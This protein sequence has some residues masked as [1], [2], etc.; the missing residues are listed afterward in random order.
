MSRVTS[1]LQLIQK[2]ELRFALADTTQKFQD[3]LNVYLAPLLLKFASQD[4]QVKLQLGKMIKFL[5]SK[6]N[7]TPELKFPAITLYEQVKSPNL[8]PNQDHTIVQS[9]TLLF[10]SKAIPRLEIDEKFDM[11][12]KILTG[13]SDMKDSVAARLFNIS[14]RLLVEL[15]F[16]KDSI[17]RIS[18]ILINLNESDKAYVTEKYYKF[19]ML[20]PVQ[21]QSNGII[22]NNISQHGL[23]KADCS[24]FLYYAGVTFNSSSLLEYKQKILKT[25][26]NVDAD[27]FDKVL[28]FLCATADNNSAIASLASTSMKRISLEYENE[29]FIETLV[30]LFTGND[31]RQ[32]VKSTLQEKILSIL[33]KSKIATHNNT[34]EKISTIGLNSTN[35]RLKQATVAFVKWFTT[36]NSLT[37]TNEES[38]LKI[39][40]QL[41]LNLSDITEDKS[42]PNH[43]ENRR[44][45]YE[46]LGL[47]LKKSNG[48]LDVPYIKFLF[49]MLSADD[50]SLQPTIIEALLGLTNSLASMKD[51]Q[52]SSLKKLL[53]NILETPFDGSTVNSTISQRRFIAVKFNN[54]SFPFS[55]AQARIMNILAQ[56]PFDKTETIEEAKKGL[57]PYLFNLN[58]L[59]NDT[60]FPS[61]HTLVKYFLKY[62][63]SIN[64][65]AAVTFALRCLIMNSIGSND[66]IVALDEHWETRVDK[67]LELDLNVKKAVISKINTL[68]DLEGDSIDNFSNSSLKHFLEFAFHCIFKTNNLS[69]LIRLT[70]II[71]LSPQFVTD[72]MSHHV[73]SL[74]NNELQYA[75]AESARYASQ[76]LGI[77]ATTPSISNGRL[78]EIIDQIYQKEHIAALGYVI[79]RSV[80]RGRYEVVRSIDFDE[81][82][83]LILKGLDASRTNL[84]SASLD[85]ISQ[86]SMFGCLGP[87]IEFSS[88]VSSMKHKFIEKI[89]PLVKK[90]FE[91][92]VY[93]WCYL[94]LSFDSS[95]H[96][97]EFTSF[98]TIILNT[99]TTKQI[100]NLFVTGEGLS[101]LSEG[102]LSNVMSNNNDI[103]SIEVTQM[104]YQS[105]CSFILDHVLNNCKTAKPNL[106]KA[107]CIWL[108]SLVQ[109]CQSST[110]NE[111]LGEI[112]KAF[113]RFLSDREE[114]I[115]D[116]ASRG[117]SITY[118]KGSYDAQETLVHDLLRSF[119]DSN[120]TS[121]ELMSGYI[122][123]D[124][125]LF[126]EGVLNTGD[127][128]SISTYK[129]VLSLASEVGNPSLVYKFMSLAKSSA[130]WSSKKG[131]A[132]G[133]S[134]ILDKEKLDRLLR[135]NPT[136]SR[137]LIPKLFRY[138]Y[139]PSPTIS[140]TM[141][142]IWNSLIIDNKKAL[143]EHF[144]FIM[145]EVLS[146][147]GNREWRI[148][149]A[150][151]TALQELLTLSDF[152]KFE[153]DLENIWMMAFR[154]MDDIK[155]SVRKEGTS[156]TRF[157]ANTMV[158]KL[159][160]TSNSKNQEI[161]LKQLVPFFLGNNG[162]LSDS[163]DV[164]KF[165]FDT[166]MKLISTASKSLKPFVSE[167]VKQLILLMSSVEPQAI[168]YLTLNADKYNLKVEDIDSQRIGIVG[169]SP[170]MEAIEKLMDLLDE[171]NI[172]HFIDELNIAVKTS[173][174]LPSKVAGSKVIVN[175]LLRNFFIVGKHGDSLLKIT[176]SQLKDR[177]ETVAKSY[178]IAC[179]YC[180]R[181]ASVKKIESFGKKLT[182]YYFE[183]KSE[184]D[185]N[186]R[187]P[188]VASVAC[189]AIANYA[190]DQF[191]S[192]SAIFLPLAFI[193]KHDESPHIAENFAKVWSD[194]T[195]SSVNAIK[196]YFNEIVLLVEQHI[197]SQNFGLRKAIAGSIIEIITTLDTRINELNPDHLRRL[198]EL[199]LESLTGRVFE[200]KEKLLDSLVK[201]SCKS[202]KFLSE[203]D[204]L[205][206]KVETRVVDEAQRKNKQYRK[207]GIFALGDFLNT[208][209]E[210]SQ[211]YETYLQL[212]EELMGATEEDSDDEASDNKMDID[213]ER[214]L[215]SSQ[216]HLA[217]MTLL[218]AIYS[219]S[220][221]N[222]INL[223]VLHFVV[224]KLN[225][226]IEKIN[227]DWLPSADSRFKYRQCLMKILTNLIDVNDKKVLPD[228][229]VNW[230]ID[231]VFN[232]WTLIKETNGSN[233]NLQPILVGFTRLTGLL[234]EKV[235]LSE[236]QQRTCITSL[237]MLKSDNVNSV[238]MIECDNVLTKFT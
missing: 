9:Y 114:I 89:E 98:E 68:Y 75:S 157:L 138:K 18:S 2:V 73:D 207:H 222:S 150:S 160:N 38:V 64:F 198:Y 156:L 136:I 44:F 131:I 176:S 202:V 80:L 106:R 180:I 39:G 135:D 32:P 34:V 143:D 186:Q 158:M 212:L 35:M 59:S 120:K 130:L 174:G 17:E 152:D 55:D 191:T 46:A 23:S 72:S 196:L 29:K 10:L 41:K 36:I 12:A 100:D 213:S 235:S 19:M 103:V 4:Q 65:E 76:L 216:I 214:K 24:F 232:L 144:D 126:D 30:D 187:L 50:K 168:N 154:A 169:S 115:Q 210:N 121:R 60:E 53:F 127:G 173:I 223:K 56:S 49:D 78:T 66:T 8:K 22:P 218:N 109:Y 119:T 86:L 190:N 1:E 215:S 124:T 67:S 91:P 203:D 118:E 204:G 116:A 146:G 128:E 188:I 45:Q 172:G 142:N 170:M 236:E 111:R 220:N 52:K 132:F 162:L 5:L 208:Y 102:W 21:P 107:S 230:F 85:C 6:Y 11:F 164:K 71:S 234:L 112:Q 92:A 93:S 43:L 99:Y 178:A 88:S 233:D 96:K 166:L 175:L 228:T 225:L 189:E 28:I 47:L 192:H 54:A 181:I 145:K 209:Y 231:S 237:K 161:I 20:Q 108:L 139:D 7:S 25:L 221:G 201:L 61:F 27:K 137:R 182:K 227:V 149:E 82:L 197:Q 13:I 123:N 40:N 159:N 229:D 63:D 97:D 74:L 194:S 51:S 238:V 58:S 94:A 134:A 42:N 184:T 57:N 105:R 110:I 31:S 199:I 148:R 113:M 117:L 15:S 26:E 69:V 70:K 81:I 183:K 153:N 185:N 14:C 141:N 33:C 48:L 167:I 177:N 165:A 62:K 125:Q 163:E 151:T 129:D 179:G 37:E 219:I 195:S 3:S 200:G 87:A 122:D 171:E 211:L 90:G 77:L 133:L 101:I 104:S 84:L 16:D 147:M 206:S 140:Q 226:L 95:S 205:Y 217:Q 155:S 83:D 224:D 193:G 79:S